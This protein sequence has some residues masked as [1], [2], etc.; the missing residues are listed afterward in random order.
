MIWFRALGSWCIEEADEFLTRA[1]S[2]IPLMYHNLSDVG[3]VIVI[4]SASLEG[5]LFWF[6]KNDAVRSIRSTHR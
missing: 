5:D 6:H 4:Q 1:D 2:S 3:S